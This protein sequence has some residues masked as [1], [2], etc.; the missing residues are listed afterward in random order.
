MNAASMGAEY[1]PHALILEGA[2]F[3]TGRSDGVFAGGI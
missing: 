3:S 2:D 1:I